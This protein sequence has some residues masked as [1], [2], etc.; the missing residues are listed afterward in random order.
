MGEKKIHLGRY[1]MGQAGTELVV[2]PVRV[3]AMP[4]SLE[5]SSFP[6]QVCSKTGRNDSTNTLLQIRHL[7]RLSI[8]TAQS[9]SKL[10]AAAAMLL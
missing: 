10:L 1:C 9:S 7:C 8:Q 3:L 6:G 5:N 2:L 4:P